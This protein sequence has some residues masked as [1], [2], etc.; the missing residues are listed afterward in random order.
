MRN[1]WKQNENGQFSMAEL[2]ATKFHLK[3]DLVLLAMGFIHPKP[4]GLLDELSIALD[5]RAMLKQ[6]K[7][8]IRHLEKMYL[9]LE[10]CVEVSHL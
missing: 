9:L 2:P 1:E 7:L 3:A 8:R 6:M 4:A 5:E 10:I